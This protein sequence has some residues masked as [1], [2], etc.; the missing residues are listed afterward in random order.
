[1][2][3]VDHDAKLQPPLSHTH[4]HTHTHE[5]TLVSLILDADSNF[6]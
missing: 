1:M 4:T 2:L 6:Q 5:P 3:I